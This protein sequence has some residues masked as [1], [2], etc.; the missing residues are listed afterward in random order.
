MANIEN[1][2]YEDMTDEELKRVREKMDR[3]TPA[4]PGGREQCDGQPTIEA[5]IAGVLRPTPPERGCVS[6]AHRASP[7]TP[8]PDGRFP[9]DDGAYRTRRVLDDSGENGR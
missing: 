1:T 8:T 9:S 3:R 5:A 2:E 6:I 4:G 7:R